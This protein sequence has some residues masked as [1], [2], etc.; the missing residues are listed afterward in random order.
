M[1]PDGRQHTEKYAKSST[2]NTHQRVW[3]MLGTNKFY[4][5]EHL[6]LLFAKG[7]PISNIVLFLCSRFVRRRKHIQIQHLVLIGSHGSGSW[8]DA[9]GKYCNREIETQE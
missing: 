9:G 1:G 2:G 3:Q 7:N 5:S 6:R 8:T 4:T